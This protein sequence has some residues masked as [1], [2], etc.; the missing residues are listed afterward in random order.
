MISVRFS[1]GLGNQMFQ[2]A[3]G[4]SLGQKNGLNYVIA[5]LSFYQKKDWNKTTSREFELGVFNINIVRKNIPLSVYFKIAGLK[6][7]KEINSGFDGRILSLVGNVEIEGYWQSERYFKNIEEIIRKEFTFKPAINKKNKEILGKIEKS[8]SVSIHVRR[9]DY[10]NDPKIRKVHGVDL[11]GYYQKAIGYINRKIKAPKYFVF[12]DDIDWCK[13]N[14][15]LRGETYFVDHNKE[16]KSYEDMRLQSNCKH[17]IIANSSF[18]WWG[19]WLNSNPGKIVLSPKKWYK[20][21]N[22]KELIPQEWL[23]I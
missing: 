22:P 15:K 14:L 19:A 7:Y 10:V 11:S 4:R 16:N 9:G 17:N 12:S 8:N 6:N 21:K 13:S 5:D 2:Y 20:R 1:G 3:C 23:R 18:S